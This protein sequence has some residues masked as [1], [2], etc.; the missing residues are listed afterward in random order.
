M[1]AGLG[2]YLQIIS[3]SLPT[4]ENFF[5]IPPSKIINLEA[6][7]GYH[8]LNNESIVDT[9][10][11][12]SLIVS[13]NNNELVDTFVLKSLENFL[14][15]PLNVKFYDRV[16]NLYRAIF[17]HKQIFF[18]SKFEYLKSAVIIYWVK[19]GGTNEKSGLKP[20]D[21]IVSINGRSF[22]NSQEADNILI[23]S[24]PEEPILYEV[25]RGTN[26]LQMNVNLSTFNINFDA[27]C[28]YFAAAIYIFFS[29]FL[30]LKH[31]DFFPI[32]LLSFA[33][34]LISVVLMFVYTRFGVN[35]VLSTVWLYVEAF[36]VSFS[37]AFL[38]HFLL[39]FPVEQISIIKRREL[40]ILIYL[41]AFAVF[42]AIIISNAFKSNVLTEFLSN[43][44][45]LP[46]VGYRVVLSLFYRKEIKSD[47]RIGIKL[48]LFLWLVVF[49]VLAYLFSLKSSTNYSNII[50][51]VFYSL[52]GIFP[53]F[54]LY[55]LSKY[56]FYDIYYRVKRNWL[57]LTSRAILDLILV[58]LLFLS[59]SLLGSLTIKFPN[60]HRSGARL[61]VLSR[62]LPPEKNLMYE[63]I[64]L[65]MLFAVFILLLFRLRR[66]ANSFLEKKFHRVQ[67]DYKKT[68][69]EF[70]ELIIRNLN[71]KDITQNVLDELANSMLL[72]KVG[73]LVFKDDALIDLK[74]YAKE[75]AEITS[76]LKS[77]YNEILTATKKVSELTS[78]EIINV[79]LARELRHSG[80]LFFSPIKYQDKV[81]GTLLLGEKLSDTK[82]TYEDRDFLKIVSKNIAIAIVN[83][84]LFEELANK[85]RY[86]KELEIAQKIQLS[87]LPKKM[88]KLDGLSIS[89]LT[90]PALEVGGDFFDFLPN[91]EK[92][93]VV[94]GDVSGKGT[95]AALYMSKVQGIL[96]TLGEFNL[97]LEE[98]VAKANELLYDNIE[99]SY[100]I[101]LIVCQFDIKKQ[102][103][104]I[105]RA[106]HLGLYYYDRRKAEI[107]KILPD[108]VALGIL[109]FKKFC[110]I[111]K[112]QE[113]EFYSGDVFLFITDGVVEHYQNGMIISFEDKLIQVLK[114]N[115]HLQPNSLAE[116]I[117]QEV[118]FID[119][120]NPLYDDLTIVI[121]KPE[122]NGKT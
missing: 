122:L 39:Y 2:V 121:V 8:N 29:L 76:K 53:I 41:I 36:A 43:F 6:I 44:S 67:F 42:L 40:V 69:K 34:L 104:K 82:Y 87:S 97:S 30:G 25:L 78:V 68:A 91:N 89:A 85:E 49:C 62:A 23:N 46:F 77:N 102:R 17:V 21:I 52:I 81:V 16:R 48:Q 100:F 58:I 14:E 110:Q 106:G 24:S 90:L 7:L 9:I 101:T 1:L 92:F 45:F 99:R 70:S 4:D 35:L 55:L 15:D 120:N 94:V 59:L 37:F 51:L 75:S 118:C 32:R 63:K 56:R 71:L 95:S 20:G 11:S 57:Y 64:A 19:P 117:L 38:S 33:L 80:Y 84:F 105:V 12:G 112:S 13:I 83:S 50:T 3:V 103:A 109:P 60:I 114:Q 65:A 66:Y 18:R 47:K 54:L 115:H 96:R 72:K 73:L 88:P 116:K 27:V 107:K 119:N 28:R 5:S 79:D 74:F 86:K 22:R 93:T 108:G 26:K 31:S 10:P 113:V 98:M 111:L 61:E